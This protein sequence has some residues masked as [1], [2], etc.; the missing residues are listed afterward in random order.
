MQ[1]PRRMLLDDKL[2]TFGAAQRRRP[3]GSGVTSN[4]RFLW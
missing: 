1:P 2:V 3:R 4:L